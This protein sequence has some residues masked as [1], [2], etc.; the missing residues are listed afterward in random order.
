MDP[1]LSAAESNQEKGRK[2]HICHILFIV[3]SFISVK[4]ISFFK[5]GVD[6]ADVGAIETR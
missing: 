6:N 1:L 3:A 2:E 4:I 5:K